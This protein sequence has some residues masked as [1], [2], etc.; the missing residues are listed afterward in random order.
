MLRLNLS[1]SLLQTVFIPGVILLVAI[2]CLFGPSVWTSLPS[3][4]ADA[5]KSLADV[6]RSPDVFTKGGGAFA[7]GI[8]AI[9][10]ILA[11]LLAMFLGLL[12]AVVSGY[13][14]YHL[15]DGWRARKLKVP[16]DD[17]QRHWDDYLDSLEKAHNSYVTKQVTAFHFEARSA[18]A[19]AVLAAGILWRSGGTFVGWVLFLIS[20]ALAV[21]LFIAAVDDHR[22]LAMFRK[23]RFDRK[24]E[25]TAKPEDALRVLVELWCKRGEVKL[26]RLV[27][28]VLGEDGKTIPKPAEA[29]ETLQTVVRLPDAEVTPSEKLV[30]S[31]AMAALSDR[32]RNFRNQAAS[33]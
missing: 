14:E 33:S 30:L 24:P 5:L 21:C 31:L 15:L 10:A 29:C 13:L 12:L 11:Y 8:L 32:A 23:R 22:M 27:L 1:D 16:D 2:G 28:P 6:L 25:T 3:S 18:I 9:G 20:L 19:L 7:T 26:L 4:V 17:Y